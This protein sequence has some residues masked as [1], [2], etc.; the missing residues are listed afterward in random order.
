MNNECNH[1][2]AK[3]KCPNYPDLLCPD[4]ALIVGE[5]KLHRECSASRRND[6]HLLDIFLNESEKFSK[7]KNFKKSVN[8][9]HPQKSSCG[10]EFEIGSK[11]FLFMA[12]SSGE[13]E[14]SVFKKDRWGSTYN[15]YQVI[16]N[17][18][19]MQMFIEETMKKSKEKLG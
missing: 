11:M 9:R 18:S 12:W 4:C 17:K 3:I 1:T 14:I 6:K 2:T 19:G 7:Y 13:I 16:Q 10:F 8:D 5:E 15:S